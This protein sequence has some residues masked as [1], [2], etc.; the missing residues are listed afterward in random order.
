[1]VEGCWLGGVRDP[2]QNPHMKKYGAWV[3]T[4]LIGFLS[5]PDDSGLCVILMWAVAV[6]HDHAAA[7]SGWVLGK[8]EGLASQTQR[9]DRDP[10]VPSTTKTTIFVGYL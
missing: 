3:G 9:V 8:S 4:E 10:K 5:I 7:S 1:M 6:G 2:A